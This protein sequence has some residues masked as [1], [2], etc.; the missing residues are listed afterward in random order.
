MAL[1]IDLVD[2]VVLVTGG[3]RG[4]GAGVSRTFLAAGATVIACAR[5]PAEAPIEVDGR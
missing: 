5:R 3:V 2:R 4:V 1:E